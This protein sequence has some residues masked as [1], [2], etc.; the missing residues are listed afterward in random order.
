M[1]EGFKIRTREGVKKSEILSDCGFRI[2]ELH[3]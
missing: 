1:R 3:Q 2:N